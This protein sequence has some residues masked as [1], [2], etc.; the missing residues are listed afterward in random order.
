[1]VEKVIGIE[2]V[3]Y[4]N[5]DQKKVIGV[6]LHIASEMQASEGSGFRVYSE[7]LNGHRPDEFKIGEI[8]AVLYQPTFGGQYKCTGVLYKDSPASK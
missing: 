1:M 8:T 7:F 2:D 3:N 6:R 5:K 4:T